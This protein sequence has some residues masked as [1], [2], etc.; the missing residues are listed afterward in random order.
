MPNTKEN[1]FFRIGRVRVSITNEDYAIQFINNAVANKLNGYICIS[2]MRT[3]SV[4]NK[5]DDYQA[6]MEN[7]LMNTPDGTPIVWCGHWW[8]LKNV[9]RACGLNI[10]PRVL[11]ESAPEVKHFLLGDTEETLALLQDKI[12]SEYNA[13]VVGVYSPPFAPIEEYDI[14]Y[15]TKLINDSGANIVWTSLRAPKQDFLNA[16]ITPRL[17]NGTIMIGVGA[18]FRNMIGDLKNPTGILQKMGLA[19]LLLKRKNSSW[20]KEIKWYAKHSLLLI[21]YFA[22]IKFRKITGTKYYELK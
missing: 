12:K 21:K 16:L 17:N 4:A 3:V 6:V 14:E 9:G 10:F 1:T 7:S 13:N 19:G 8:G 18:A 2:N 11:K 5:D 15:I 22:I 20:W